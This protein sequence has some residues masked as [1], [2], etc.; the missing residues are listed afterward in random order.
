MP[1]NWRKIAKRL[2]DSE[3]NFSISTFWDAGIEVKLGDEM[4]GFVARTDFDFDDDMPMQDIFKW[5]AEETCKHS[6]SSAFA[7]WYCKK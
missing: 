2:Y 6:P 7:K 4:N 1:E 3:V 5:L